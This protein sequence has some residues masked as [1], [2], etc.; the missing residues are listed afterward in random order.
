M[1]MKVERLHIDGATVILFE[2]DPV[3]DHEQVLTMARA[4][5]EAIERDGE[6]RLLLDLSRTEIF[7]VGAFL[8]PKGLLTSIR[9]IGPVSRYAVVGAPS[10]AAVAVESFGAIL[11]LKSRAFEAADIAK[12]RRWVCGFHGS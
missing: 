7:A 9:S 3:L 1:A 2:F 6:L 10:V 8:S 12:A 11:P 5:D 4:V